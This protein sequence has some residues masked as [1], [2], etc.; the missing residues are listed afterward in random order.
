[1]MLYETI[2]VQNID[3]VYNHDRLLRASSSGVGS[4][5]YKIKWV[6]Q[7]RLRR[8][9]FNDLSFDSYARNVDIFLVVVLVDDDDDDVY[10]VIESS[11][12]SIKLHWQLCLYV[13]EF[14]L[15]LTVVDI[16]KSSCRHIYT[17]INI[18]KWQLELVILLILQ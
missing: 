13:Y 18:E 1:M 16:N 5:R 4:M 15:K 3:W 9:W 6:W 2:I 11:K 7:E 14:S 8:V 12:C 17:Y 10:V